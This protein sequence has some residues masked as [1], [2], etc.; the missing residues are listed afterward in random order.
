MVALCSNCHKKLDNCND[1]ARNGVIETLR[2][3][4]VNI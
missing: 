1:K 2:K 4:G 3:N